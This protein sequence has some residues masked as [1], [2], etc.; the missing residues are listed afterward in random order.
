MKNKA[1]F[2][3][4]DGIICEALPRGEYLVDWSE[5]KLLPGIE[6]FLAA[7]KRKEYRLF[8]ITNQGQI[9]K[10]LM[11]VETLNEVHKNMREL[12]L[13]MIDEVYYCP[14]KS[15]DGCECRKPKP[16]L[17]FRA[18]QDFNVDPT[19]SF[20]IGDSDKDVNAGE[21]IG[22]RTIFLKNE[23]NAEELKKCSPDFVCNTLA[24]MKEII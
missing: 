21:A 3:D 6:D 19:R 23:H 2:L 8:V 20:F 18:I 1:L 9:A 15:G 17:M 10:G 5:F 11:K 24:E 12:L 14:H 22:A 7:A 13:G 4:R 16:A